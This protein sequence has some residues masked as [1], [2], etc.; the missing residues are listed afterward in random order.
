MALVGPPVKL[1]ALVVAIT[2]TEGGAGDGVDG[3]FPEDGVG[4]GFIDA[5]FDDG[6]E[7]LMQHV[8]VKCGLWHLGWLGRNTHP[9]HPLQLNSG[10]AGAH[11][12]TSSMQVSIP[13]LK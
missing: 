2:K 3:G 12:H 13:M 4:P 1:A 11:L 8:P 5:A 9:G 7:A 6:L 10:P